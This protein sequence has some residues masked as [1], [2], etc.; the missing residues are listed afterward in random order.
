MAGKPEALRDDA[1]IAATARVHN[2]TVST[3]NEK[4]F[5]RFGVDIYNPFKFR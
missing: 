4:D 5:R 1:M 2:L 3:R